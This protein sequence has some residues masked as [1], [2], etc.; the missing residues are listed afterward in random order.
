MKILPASGFLLAGLTAGII[1]GNAGLVA[2]ATLREE[3]NGQSAARS[4][5]RDRLAL[6]DSSLTS[7]AR[8][9][10]SRPAELA[11]L[12]EMAVATADPIE[13]H[14]LLSECLLNMTAENW[15]EVVSS[16][17][18]LSNETGRDRE[19]QWKLA[20]FRSGQ[21]AGEAA[22]DSYLSAGLK[23][24]KSEAWEVLYG[25]SSKDPRAAL[26]WLKNAE[27]A[28]KEISTENYNAVIAGTALGNP[29]DALA[30]LDGISPQHRQGIAGHLVWN[31][32]QN[33]GTDALDSVIQYA[34]KLDASDP[35]AAALAG[36]LF[37]EV[38]EKLLWKADH[39]RDVGQAGD[40][41]IKLA[42]SG[43]DPTRITQQ[44]LRKYRYYSMPDKLNLLESVNA[45]PHHSELDQTVLTATVLSGLNEGN[46]DVEAIKN[47]MAQHP[48]SRLVPH[49]KIRVPEN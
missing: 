7:I 25:W 48:N 19:N 16:F 20:L 9:R 4:T 18:K 49:L 13:S 35:N 47:W 3:S 46:G 21:V 32:T 1:I 11:G 44:A 27:A 23:N 22:M 14:R 28:G 31:T 24:K 17:N 42:E 2:P 26:A 15:L 37:K 5:K 12:T 36:D 41:V 8:I 30:L 10:Q 43:L 39:A 38:T 6:P 40:V 29:N 34:S 45:A 33:G